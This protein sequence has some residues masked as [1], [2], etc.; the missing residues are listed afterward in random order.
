MVEQVGG[1]AYHG[2]SNDQAE[3]EVVYED[4]FLVSRVSRC[5]LLDFADALLIPHTKRT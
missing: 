1:T 5:L 3:D 4:Y 2:K